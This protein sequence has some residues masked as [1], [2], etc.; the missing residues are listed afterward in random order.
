MKNIKSSYWFFGGLILMSLLFISYFLLPGRLDGFAQCVTD[1][2]ATFYGAFW[3][4]HC[5][6]QKQLF[7]KSAGN[8]PYVECS[9]PDGQN[10]QQICKDAGIQGYPTWVFEDGERETKTLTP[11]ELAEKTGCELPQ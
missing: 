8:L 10:Q 5:K 7:G 2:G 9:T 1:R 3:C 11:T 6:E 4:P